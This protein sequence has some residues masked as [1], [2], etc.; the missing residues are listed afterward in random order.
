MFNTFQ[1][2]YE[3]LHP[4]VTAHRLTI[5]TLGS[6]NSSHISYAVDIFVPTLMPLDSIHFN[7]HYA[8]VSILHG[9][10]SYKIYPPL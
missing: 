5:L 10:T 8:A 4:C 6:R 3:P 1:L 2:A 7:T 9:H